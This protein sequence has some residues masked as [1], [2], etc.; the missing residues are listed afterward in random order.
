MDGSGDVCHAAGPNALPNDGR[1][2]LAVGAL[3]R[4]SQNISSARVR[5]HCLFHDFDDT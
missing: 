4:K 1:L 3:T 2:W 5:W